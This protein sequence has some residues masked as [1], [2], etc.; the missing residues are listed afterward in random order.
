M[1]PERIGI[2]ERIDDLKTKS[3]WNTNETPSAIVKTY[4]FESYPE[5]MGFLI[6]VGTLAEEL[7]TVPTISIEDGNKVTLLLGEEPTAGVTET[8]V[9]FAEAL[10]TA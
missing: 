10:A 9:A 7:G 2:T 5:A 3:G 8:D 1:K 6:E 4:E